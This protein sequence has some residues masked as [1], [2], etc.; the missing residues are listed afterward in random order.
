MQFL[1]RLAKLWLLL[2]LLG[3]TAYFSYFNRE[4]V[5]ISL[6]PWGESISV[7]A[8]AAFLAI[9][10][11]GSF[12][13]T[14]FLGL[15]TARKTLELRRLTRRLAVLDPQHGVSSP[16]PERES[17]RTPAIDPSAP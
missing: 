6:P 8:F 5:L 11:V 16:S 10:F 17:L 9:F 15:E 13:T 7:P 1:G 4:R 3:T 14:I 2:G 12:V